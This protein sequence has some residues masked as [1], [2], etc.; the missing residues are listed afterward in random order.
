M[1]HEVKQNQKPMSHEVEQEPM[2]LEVEQDRKPR[3]LVIT[4]GQRGAPIVPDRAG[5]HPDAPHRSA[6]WTEDPTRS[7]SAVRQPGWVAS[8]A[9][10]RSAPWTEVQ[11]ARCPL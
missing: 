3:S 6:P 11:Q 2:S 10:H 4:A 8:G 5:S 9:P 7:L 1:S